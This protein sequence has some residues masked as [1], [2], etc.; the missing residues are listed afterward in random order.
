MWRA[1][2]LPPNSPPLPNRAHPCRA[3]NAVAS[4]AQIAGLSMTTAVTLAG[5]AVVVAA[6]LVAALPPPRLTAERR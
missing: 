6:G 2:A 1:V 5:G 4:F 3:Y